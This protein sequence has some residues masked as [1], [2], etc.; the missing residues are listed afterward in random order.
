MTVVAIFLDAAE[1]VILGDMLVTGVEQS[2]PIPA[3]GAPTNLFP[4]GHALSGMCQKITVLT[5]DCV[6]GWAGSAVGARW[7]INGLRKLSVER[8][9]TLSTV[10]DFLDAEDVDTWNNLSIIGMATHISPSGHRST[11]IFHRGTVER[12]WAGNEYGN[13]LTI[14]CGIDALK[15]QI[16]DCPRVTDPNDH[17]QSAMHI[18]V[19]ALAALLLRSEH[20]NGYPIVNFAIGGAY[21]VAS[22][23]DDSFRK[24]Y[25]VGHIAYNVTV[26]STGRIDFGNPMFGLRNLPLGRYTAIRS[27]RIDANPLTG[28]VNFPNDSLDLVPGVEDYFKTIKKSEIPTFPSLNA[29]FTYHVFHI[30]FEADTDR[31]GIAIHVESNPTKADRLITFLQDETRI[32]FCYSDTFSRRIGEWLDRSLKSC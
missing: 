15:E 3:I 18:R 13:V 27:V 6:L 9:L 11:M 22:Y 29:S 28:T 4:D 31:T 16:E 8:T 12:F 10:N 24:I 30:A 5:T 21:E 14:G 26:R 17:S 20:A 19:W 25:D 7:I 1:P 2:L 32:G 23:E